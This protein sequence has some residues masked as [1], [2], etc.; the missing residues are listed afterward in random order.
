VEVRP[1]ASN[2][3]RIICRRPVP[4]EMISR[5]ELLARY[6]AE[7]RRDPIPDP[8]SRVERVGPVVRIVGEESYVIFSDLRESNVLAIVAEEAAFF[9]RAGRE[10]EWKVFGHDQPRDIEVVLAAAG[11][12]PEEPETLVAYDLR[13][14]VPGQVVPNGIEVRRVNDAAGLR[15]A[16]AADRAAFGPEGRSS[17]EQWAKRMSDPNQAMFVAYVDGTPVA[18]G[19]LE[20]TPG[21]SFAGLYGGGTSPEYRHRG[22]YRGLVAA[23]GALALSRGYRYLTVDARDTSRPILER[24]GFVPLTTTRGWVLRPEHEAPPGP[25]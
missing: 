5:D 16:S 12:V 19:R 11:F 9:R 20:M 3:L 25:L 13:D 17:T 7:M 21:R 22:I 6:D 1:V 23:R 24:L 2:S 4:G 10:V 8:G 18:T 15:D 14:G